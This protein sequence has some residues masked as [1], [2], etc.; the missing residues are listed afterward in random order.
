MSKPPSTSA[1]ATPAGRSRGTTDA[2]ELRPPDAVTAAQRA[3]LAQQREVRGLCA[4]QLVARGYSPKQIAALRSIAPAEV[5]R[6]LGRAVRT[7]RATS[8]AVA[9]HE[10]TRRGLIL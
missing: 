3:L 2:V 10:A 4:L 5:A 8:V 6:D 1:I 9:I 7:L